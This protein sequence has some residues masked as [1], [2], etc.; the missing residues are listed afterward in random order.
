MHVR[1]KPTDKHHGRAAAC[2]DGGAE[3]RWSDLPLKI[4]FKKIFIFDFRERGWERERGRETSIGCLLYTSQGTEPATQAC[5][6][7]ENQTGD[8]SVLGMMPNQLSHT[9]QGQ[10]CILMEGSVQ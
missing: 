2:P 5:V 4:L 3:E 7:T 10:T 8:L 9:S 6:L 1:R